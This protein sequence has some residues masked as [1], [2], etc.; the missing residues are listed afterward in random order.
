MYVYLILI[1]V[2]ALMAYVVY[3]NVKFYNPYKLYMVFGKKGAGKST[4]MTKLARKYLAKG[5]QVF[6]TDYVEGAYY[7]PP[8]KIGKVTIPPESLLLVDEVGLIFNNRDYKNFGADVRRWFKLQRHYHVKV[9]LF[10]QAFDVDKQIRDL[11]DYLFLL[12][13]FLGIFAICRRIE[14]TI[15]VVDAEHGGSDGAHLAD[16][17]QFSPWYTY[18]F[19][20][21][22]VTFIPRWSKYFRSFDAP[23][24]PDYDFEPWK[25]GM[26]E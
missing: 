2:L 12:T 10:S 17:L 18:L 5:W 16:Q 20:G 13:N 9:Y 8:D 14:R 6:S 25:E 15:A 26:N 3:L 1:P 21:L 7:I 22:D 24:L 4:Y 19:G 23:V 11:T